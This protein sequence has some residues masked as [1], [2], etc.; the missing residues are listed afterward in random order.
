MSFS[1]DPYRTLGLV[2]G[3]TADEVKR[4]Y[5]RL[6]K[7]YHPDTAGPGAIPR[8]LAIQAAYERIAGGPGRARPAGPAR[9]SEADPARARATRDA[10]RA[11]SRAGWRSGPGSGARTAAGQGAGGQRSGGP[12]DA[13]WWEA[14]RERADP[15][16]GA[17]PAGAGARRPG[18]DQADTR[19]GGSA[20]GPRGSGAGPRSTPRRKAT[21]SSTSYDDATREPRHPSWD[22]GAWYGP[23]SGTYWTI[24]P[25]EYADPRKHGPEYQER[26]RRA[27]GVDTS[28]WGSPGSE[29]ERTAAGVSP[30][31]PASGD[32]AGPVDAAGSMDAGDAMDEGSPHRPE[33][34]RPV[35]GPAADAGTDE[36][37]RAAPQPPRAAPRP[38]P[39][40][41]GRTTRSFP[42]AGPTAEDPGT[43][44][45]I[46][47][48]AGGQVIAGVA[49][50]G[51]VAG[52]VT[53]VPAVV[54]FLAASMAGT[55]NLML[56]ALAAPLVVGLVTALAM[57][58]VRVA[59]RG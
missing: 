10:H 21:Y 22:G 25:R 37:P 46:A 51:L 5:R 40:P 50:I 6:V 14:G 7:R 33:S 41:A 23:S 29:S 15:A 13:S 12:Q 26:A 16:G 19:P 47:P 8:F 31:G 42:S 28:G 53:A 20:R 24:N 57:L 38:R 4:A 2:P 58:G 30:G 35:A 44:G 1:A 59:R 32:A 49:S 56:V 9:P 27:S 17:R 43:G 52:A 18:A 3:A 55:S 48:Q 54:V 45:S 34:G 39:A 36:P 11:W